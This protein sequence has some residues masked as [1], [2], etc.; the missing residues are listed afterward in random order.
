MEIGRARQILTADEIFDLVREDLHGVE[1]AIGIESVP[2]VDTVTPIS[3]YLRQ[4]GGERLR[5]ALLLMCARFAGGGG[6]RMA[7]Q[8]GAVVEMLHAAAL[9][10]GHVIDVEQTRRGR[11]STNVQWANSTCVLA[12]DWLYARAFR[13]ALEER[14]LDQAI[15]AAQMMVMG[16]LIQLNRIGCI[17]V[18]EADCMEVVDRKTA[19]LFSVCGKLGAVTAG[20]DTRDG[21]KLGEFAW[22]LGMAFHLID[23]VLDFVSSES[24]PGRPA[25]GDLKDG[26][27]TLPMVYA[28]EQASVSERDLVAG[29][30]RD[31]SYDAIPF[32]NVLALVDRYNGIQ[33][34]RARARRFTDRARQIVAEFPDSLCRRALFTLTDLVAERDC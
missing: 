31:R 3:K 15:G 6:G 18:T 25:G 13:V 21:E 20:A 14:V 7:I 8:L 16:E 19:S 4:N 17:G 5:A 12:G 24:T 22:N 28:L 1:K 30:L 23:D 34:T 2:S 9:V 10:H 32:A 29:V 33:R 11:S 27:V 26:K